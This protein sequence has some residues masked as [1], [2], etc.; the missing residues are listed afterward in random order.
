MPTLTTSIQHSTGSPRQ[1]NQTRKRNKRHPNR[2]ERSKTV[3]I[4]KLHSTIIENLKVSTYKILELRSEFSKVAGYKVNIQK[5][6]VFLYTDN[7]L[8]ERE[9]KKIFSFKLASKRIKY[10]GINVTKEVKDLYSENYKTLVK[11]FENH[12]KKWKDNWCSGN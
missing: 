12:T 8:S 11:E 2:K 3:T 5:S 10:L 9:G 6:V 4:C 1:S 7:E